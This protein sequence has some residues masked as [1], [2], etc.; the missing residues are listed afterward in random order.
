MIKFEKPSTSHITLVEDNS[1]KPVYETIR[2]AFFQL[3]RATSPPVDPPEIK[4]HW[5][6]GGVTD[7]APMEAHAWIENLLDR[8]TGTERRGLYGQLIAI[9]AHITCSLHGEGHPNSREILGIIRVALFTLAAGLGENDAAKV[10]MKWHLR[11]IPIKG[12]YGQTLDREALVIAARLGNLPLVN[13]L[14]ESAPSPKEVTRAIVAAAW[15]GQCEAVELLRTQP[16][17]QADLE[18]DLHTC[19]SSAI[20]DGYPQHVAGLL[21]SVPFPDK[22]IS[23]LIFHALSCLNLHQEWA[24][25]LDALC[26]NLPRSQRDSFLNSEDPRLV[27]AALGGSTHRRGA[28]RRSSLPVLSDNSLPDCRHVLRY[29]M[30]ADPHLAQKNNLLRT[31]TGITLDPPSSDQL[32][33]LLSG[34]LPTASDKE[35]LFE[36]VTGRKPESAQ[37]RDSLFVALFC[38]A[39]LVP[40]QMEAL[41]SARE[42]LQAE[43]C[44][45]DV[46]GTTNSPL[47]DETPETGRATLMIGLTG[48]MNSLRLARMVDAELGRQAP[49]KRLLAA[50]FMHLTFDALDRGTE[51]KLAAFMKLDTGSTD[52]LHDQLGLRAAFWFAMHSGARPP[53][54]LLLEK[55]VAQMT[56]RTAASVNLQLA[57]EAVVAGTTPEQLFSANRVRAR[58]LLVRVAARTGLNGD[59]TGLVVRKILD[60]DENENELRLPDILFLS[61]PN[62]LVSLLKNALGK[63]K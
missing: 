3:S 27:A 48:R 49:N 35:R 16:H 45:L 10:V 29:D 55:L 9:E 26:S 39:T 46:T 38:E 7:D 58:R 34:E 21:K 23:A 61:D 36:A 53:Y 30:T 40:G 8:A 60:K 52:D 50:A 4:K 5:T 18:Q 41:V 19:L 31:L 25:G 22:V 15:R 62:V 37:A 42:C 32:R 2:D 17:V 33:A 57:N 47:W 54:T 12:V 43:Q 6:G 56:Y 51:E 44:L 24:I 13:W 11:E 63:Q 28:M 14:I 20:R 1:P 59:L